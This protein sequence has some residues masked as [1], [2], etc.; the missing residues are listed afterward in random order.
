MLVDGKMMNKL[1][2]FFHLIACIVIYI[3]TLYFLKDNTSLKIVGDEF[4]YW[5]AG[6][7]F[8][9]LDWSEVA[10]IN[11]YYNYGYGLIL[12]LLLKLNMNA[13]FTYQLAIV[14]N[15]IMLNLVYVLIFRLLNKY[16][17]NIPTI[18][19]IIISLALTLSAGNICF[20]QYTMPEVV[21]VL[22]YWSIVYLMYSILEKFEYYKLI[23]LTVAIGL[24]F[25][26]HLRLIGIVF[27]Q[28]LFL[29][30]VVRK[31]RIDVKRCVGVVALFVLMI[32]FVFLLKEYYQQD[33]LMNEYIN[34]Q[35]LNDF[36]G[37]LGKIKRIFTLEGVRM[38]FDSFMGKFF[39]ACS[40]SFLFLLDAI[41]QVFACLKR[42][43]ATKKIEKSD[44]FLVFLL[45]N[46]IAMI[47]VG[48]I[49]MMSSG[50]RFDMQIYGRYFEFT[51]GPLVLVALTT[52]LKDGN[53]LKR[54]PIVV[55]VYF[56][57]GKYIH[58]T[59]PYEASRA[60]VFINC[61]GIADI[62]IDN[63]NDIMD[64]VVRIVIIYGILCFLLNVKSRRR[65]QLVA[66]GMV[67]LI[68]YSVNSAYTTYSQGCL[69]WASG[70]TENEE[71][72][73]TNIRNLGIQDDLCYYASDPT[74]S[75]HIKIDYMQ[76]LLKET[77]IRCIYNPEQIQEL[78]KGKYLLTVKGTKVF[79]EE[80]ITG[81]TKVH[82]SDTLT[83]WQV[84]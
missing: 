48:S 19:K 30:Y 78:D 56:L 61:S 72:L 38:L 36:S 1:N 73:A 21:C 2:L 58:N 37:Q 66:V 16:V 44:V 3:V 67:M 13:T 59:I 52:Y 46:V 77:P 49:F 76:F 75:D 79:D 24:C 53:S 65:Y 12:M 82:E 28:V 50:A 39:Y 80:F 27:V 74:I 32:L 57:L 25:T 9:G 71:R 8:S 34:I 14:V 33:Y 23:L 22:L 41:W 11:S 51:L 83:L 70:Q 6:A 54:L 26:I 40:I 20:A 18:V 10:S 4:G 64:V 43:I 69:S 62:L 15:A 47:M 35:G 63:G 42:T 29:V 60:N 55:G 17:N 84:Q 45:L 81:F 68:I 31:E 5:A 7:F